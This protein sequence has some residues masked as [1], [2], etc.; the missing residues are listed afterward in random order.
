MLGD[1]TFAEL[2]LKPRF[3]G[4]GEGVARSGQARSVWPIACD[5]PGA[6]VRI[7]FLIRN[8]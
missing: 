4:T 7:C 6:S 8:D 1:M 3:G 2:Q 5:H